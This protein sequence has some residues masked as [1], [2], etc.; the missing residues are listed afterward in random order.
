M[1]T[2]HSYVCYCCFS[3]TLEKYSYSIRRL[4]ETLL[5]FIA[6]SL[7]LRPSFFNEMFGEAVQAVR[8]NYYPPC[9]RPDLVLGL[10]PHSDGSA[11]TVLQQDTASVGLQIL[12][13]GAWI[14][15]HPIAT[16]LV[17]NVGDT[18]E[19]RAPY[20]SVEHRAV[21]NRESDRLSLVTFYSP[22]YEI[23]LGPVPEMVNDKP[24]MYRR[25]NHGEYSRHYITNKLE[26]K[27]RLE[28][29]R[30]QTSL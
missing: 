4:C 7:G 10:T 6:E 15:V 14:P 20:K 27:K 24:C 11:L 1:A 22:S 3:E 25:Y 12:K 21:T 28:F 13:D 9:S 29:A 19:V 8:M 17:V 23:E 26:G 2:I 5:G 30:I 16:A 18:L